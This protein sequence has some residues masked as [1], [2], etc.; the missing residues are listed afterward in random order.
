MIDDKFKENNNGE[1]MEKM[2][3][4]LLLSWATILLSWLVLMLYAC[5]NGHI[6]HAIILAVVLAAFVYLTYMIA[7]SNSDENIFDGFDD[8]E[9]DESTAY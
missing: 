8:D 2:L 3:K 7:K 4:M 6:L 1:N 9:D 5:N